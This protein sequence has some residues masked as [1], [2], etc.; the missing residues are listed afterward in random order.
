M[1]HKNQ[2]G[3]GFLRWQWCSSG[4]ALQ[5]VSELQYFD[6]G[7]NKKEV[8]IRIWFTRTVTKK[9]KVLAIMLKIGKKETGKG[10]FLT[11]R[12]YSG[13]MLYLFITILLVL[14]ALSDTFFFNV[15][16]T[17]FLN[18]LVF[19]SSIT[20]WINSLRYVANC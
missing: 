3:S 19:K 4:E 8:H 14:F 11:E 10:S 9:L 12:K 6:N 20:E 7:R 17:F 5:N 2:E 1:N 18:E 15:R 13:C 16:F